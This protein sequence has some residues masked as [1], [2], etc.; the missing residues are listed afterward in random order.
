MEDRCSICGLW[1]VSKTADCPECGA[2]MDS[3]IKS[4]T[5]SWKCRKCDYGI[6][7]MAKLLCFFDNKKF[8]KECYSKI[9]NCPYAYK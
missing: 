9:N 4:L 3:S 8:A 1:N 2:I 5:L 7:T 6:A